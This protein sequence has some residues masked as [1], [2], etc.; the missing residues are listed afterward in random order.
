[1]EILLV[2]DNEGDRRLVRE[3][4]RESSAPISMRTVSDGMEALDFLQQEVAHGAAL[5]PDL[6]LLDWNLPK[7]GGNEVL[8]NIKTDPALKHI[9]VVIL[10]SSRAEED[11]MCA[12]QQGANCYLVKPLGLDDYLELLRATV[13]FWGRIARLPS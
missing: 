4:L 3:A 9:P 1:M 2:E 13:D 11:V 10:T 5:R 7:R 6:I 8:M 12:Y